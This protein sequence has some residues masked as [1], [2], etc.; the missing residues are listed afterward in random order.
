[1]LLPSSLEPYDGTN[2]SSCH[3][4]PFDYRKNVIQS[5]IIDVSRVNALCKYL[6]HELAEVNALEFVAFTALLSTHACKGCEKA[7]SRADARKQ[8]KKYHR[9]VEQLTHDFL[10]TVG[11]I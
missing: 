11:T 1:M 7:V 4:N 3:Y 9:T 10:V 5:G 8:K 2:H 6:S